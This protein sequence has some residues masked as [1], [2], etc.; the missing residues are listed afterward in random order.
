MKVFTAFEEGKLVI[1]LKGE[2]DQHCARKVMDDI[3]GLIDQYMPRD[4]VLDMSG[5]SFM[6]SSG[7]AVILR[8][9]RRMNETGGRIWVEN[10]ARQP[11]KVIEA[12]GIE[13]IVRV[14]AKMKEVEV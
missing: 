1:S 3:S 4:C 7:I 14:S 6:D 8:T 5:V 11:Y 9:H 12:S 2:L 13:R 10:P